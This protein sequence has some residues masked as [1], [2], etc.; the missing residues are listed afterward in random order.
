MI[1]LFVQIRKLEHLYQ[2][3]S[4]YKSKECVVDEKKYRKQKTWLSINF[5]TTVQYV[6]MQK[7]PQMMVIRYFG[8]NNHVKRN[9]FYASR[10]S[11]FWFIVQK[12]ITI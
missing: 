8:G 6:G 3:L 4:S 5:I 1:V 7:I 10:E 11:N 12:G 2:Q 9:G